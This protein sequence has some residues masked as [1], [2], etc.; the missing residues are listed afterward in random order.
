MHPKR[1][2]YSTP[3]PSGLLDFE[4]LMTEEGHGTK[5]IGIQS[6]R[7]ELERRLKDHELVRVR[8]RLSE[9]Y[10]LA[11]CHLQLDHSGIPQCI[12]IRL[13]EMKRDSHGIDIL[14][15]QG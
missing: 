3:T 5:L 13:R 15:T 10:F 7:R 8:L 4:R 2:I 6:S 1:D 9:N 12:R 11:L 14:S